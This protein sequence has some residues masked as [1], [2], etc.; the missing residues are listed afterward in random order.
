[1]SSEAKIQFKSV[2]RKRPIRRNN[3][4]SEE[5]K[6]DDSDSTK[7]TLEELLELQKLRKRANGVNA[8]TLAC[9]KKLSKEEELINSDPDPFKIRT[10]GLLTLETAKKAAAAEKESEIG[11]QFSK[12]TRIRDEDEEMKK[13]IEIEMEKR[14]GKKQDMD[15]NEH[16][17]YLSPEEQ[18]L[19]SLPD[20]LK[21]SQ[22]K[23]KLP[24][25]EF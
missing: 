2:K 17:K 3:S 18:A 9:G 14:R 15:G 11:T 13:F 6:D 19:M 7:D 12:E 23:V 1:M 4:D 16:Q 8:V 22:S 25:S 5:N 10:G 24:F 21:K 20:H